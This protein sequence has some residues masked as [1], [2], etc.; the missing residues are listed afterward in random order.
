MNFNELIDRLEVL[1]S[2]GNEGIYKA[3]CGHIYAEYEA[4]KAE[5]MYKST[6]DMLFIENKKEKKSDKLAESEAR[7]TDIYINKLDVYLDSRRHANMLKAKVKSLE[8]EKDAIKT[9]IS[10]LQSQMKLV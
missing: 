4:D 3:S 2:E 1:T 6:K 10:A 9:K 7:T 8:A 5:H